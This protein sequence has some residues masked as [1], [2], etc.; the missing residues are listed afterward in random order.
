[1]TTQAKNNDLDHLIDP[2]FRSINRLFV[3]S[4]KNGVMILQQILLMSITCH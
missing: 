4:F 1:M 2:T 3:I